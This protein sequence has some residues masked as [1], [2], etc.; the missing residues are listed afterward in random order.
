MSG[1]V[2]VAAGVMVSFTVYLALEELTQ[3]WVRNTRPC[4]RWWGI[5]YAVIPI[6]GWMPYFFAYFPAK[7]TYDS[8]WQWAQ[9]HHITPY[10]NWHPILDTWIIE[11][12]S[13]LYNSPA[14]YIVL[15]I[16]VM[17]CVVAY[18]LRFLQT[19]GMP[20]WLVLTLDFFYA[21]NPAI[22]ILAITMWKDILFAALILFFTTMVAKMVHDPSW[23]SP[24]RHVLLLIVVCFLVM[25][26]RQNGPETV[27]ASLVVLTLILKELRW[28]LVAVSASV[29]ALF[30]AFNGPVLRYY[31]VIRNPLNEALAIPT[32][33]IAATYKYGGTFTPELKAYFNRILPADH[34]VK[35]YNPYT[36]N[37][38]KW[39][40]QYR[41][42]VITDNFPAYL[43][44]WAH[45]LV[46]NPG[47]F[48]RAYMDQT[49]E[50][51]QFSS[52]SQMRPYLD[53][54]LNLQDYA[55][56]VRIRASSHAANPTIMIKESY[57]HYVSTLRS[58]HTSQPL[59]TYAEFTEGI[60]R[61]LEP[62]HTNSRFADLRSRIDWV[63]QQMAVTWQNYFV[64]GA[65]P[66]FLLI[67]SLVASIRRFGS[68][69]LA[70]YLPAIF[71]VVTLAMSMPA[72]DFRYQFG[73][74]FTVPF[75]LF[76]PKLCRGNT[77]HMLDDNME[78]K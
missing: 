62:L 48:I 10:N 41:S 56:S 51:W 43:R 31:H 46:L 42:S 66:F 75:L 69:G 73:F 71:V 30:L 27:L 36:V 68:R 2:F 8:F 58:F 33:Q 77:Q 19:M 17:A 65:I 52:P 18:A 45:L 61:T 60:Q 54:P 16:I 50:I 55:L 11:A 47:I 37:P 29:L 74:A 32:Q 24:W 1:I 72:T 64:K 34:W 14:S 4:A 23:L 70:V 53:T 7:M 5:L 9:A 6:A 57:M 59:P 76:Y 25:N 15:Q 20:Q 49:A 40:P 67:L 39:D 22:G 78:G 3:P 63:F 35:D 44:N 26:M 38:I 12:T 28:R 21:L 13:K